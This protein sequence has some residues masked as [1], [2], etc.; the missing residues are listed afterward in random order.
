MQKNPKLLEQKKH[1][2]AIVTTLKL[3][4][5]KFRKGKV[6]RNIRTGAYA[7]TS[8]IYSIPPG[9]LDKLKSHFTEGEAETLDKIITAPLPAKQPK[10]P[11][12]YLKDKDH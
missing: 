7:P 5:A 9:T 3:Q 12:H 8:D 6:E 10:P 4:R 2:A 11:F 1:N